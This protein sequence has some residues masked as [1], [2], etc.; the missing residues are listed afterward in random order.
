LC[1]ALGAE[2]GVAEFRGK[3]RGL[4][5]SLIAFILFSLG[6]SWSLYWAIAISREISD[7]S[8]YSFESFMPDT[9]AGYSAFVRNC[10]IGFSVLGVTW[11]VVGLALQLHAVFSRQTDP[12][13]L[14]RG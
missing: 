2:I 1:C 7:V 4:W 13:S 8:L 6:Q 5:L 3:L 12:T 11:A 10:V 14:R 9:A